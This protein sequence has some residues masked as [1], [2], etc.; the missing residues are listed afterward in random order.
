MQ[1]YQKLRKMFEDGDSARDAGLVTP[2]DV[3]RFDNISYGVHGE[4]NL[5]D[6]YRPEGAAQP[7]PVIVSVHGGGWVYG[8]KDVYQ[9]YCMSLAQH[10]F[11]VVNFSYRLSPE[12]IYPEHLQD[13]NAVMHWVKAH[14][15]EYGGDLSRLCMIGDSAGAQMAAMYACALTNP[16]VRERLS[17]DVPEVRIRA[18]ALNCGVYEMRDGLCRVDGSASPEEGEELVRTVLG[19]DYGEQ[20]LCLGQPADFVTATFPP[21][22]VMTSNGDFLRNQQHIMIDAL[23]RNGVPYEF[24]EYGDETE[25]LWHVFHCNIRSDAARVCNDAECDFFRKWTSPALRQTPAEYADRARAFFTEGYNCSQAVLM[26]FAEE[27]GISLS[28]AAKIASSFGGGMGRLREVCG[29]VSGMFM[30]AGLLCGYDDPKDHS[31]KTAHYKR[32]QELAAE[33]RKKNGSIIC[34]ELLGLNQTGV[35]HHEPEKRTESY[36][37]KRPCKE[38]V[39]DAAEIAARYLMK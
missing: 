8:D 32:V 2:E 33:F 7:L 13:V 9:H 18:I 34:R 29:A 28:M 24:H 35:S 12:V 38:L 21:A 6:V 22:F 11:V 1:V 27:L 39:G 3:E 14:L 20:A 19:E 16:D 10:G 30:T 25:T 37:K 15:P 5:L 4:W 36:Y 17:L 26:A 31:E 23:E